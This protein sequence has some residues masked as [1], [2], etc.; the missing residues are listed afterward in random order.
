MS[1]IILDMFFAINKFTIQEW[2]M[3][4]IGYNVVRLYFILCTIGQVSSL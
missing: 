4:T 1:I 2:Y 3:S